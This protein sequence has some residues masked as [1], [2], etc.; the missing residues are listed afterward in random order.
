MRSV[1]EVDQKGFGE[2]EVGMVLEVEVKR[3]EEMDVK[4]VG[5][6]GEM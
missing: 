4:R 3:V 6:V 1:K 2:T 5:M